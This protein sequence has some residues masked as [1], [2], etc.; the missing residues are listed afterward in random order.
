MSYNLYIYFRAQTSNYKPQ[1]LHE[2]SFCQKQSDIKS[3]RTIE[4]SDQL[5]ITMKDTSEKLQVFFF[6]FLHRS[7]IF[8]Y[9]LKNFNN[10]LP[11]ERFA[12]S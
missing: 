5:R 4:L 9:E 10:Y 1:I 7:E 3:G 6:I 8:L 2:S 12:A 11:I